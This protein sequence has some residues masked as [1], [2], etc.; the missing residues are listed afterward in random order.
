MR[1]RKTGAGCRSQVATG[2]IDRD[3]AGRWEMSWIGLRRYRRAGTGWLS[4]GGIAAGARPVESRLSGARYA[5]SDSGM[6]AQ[7]K[8]QIEQACAVIE[9]RGLALAAC[10][11]VGPRR[12]QGRWSHD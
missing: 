7:H 2:R 12:M 1:I 4:R 8:S 6:H 3:V 10:P 5:Y 9:G 11:G